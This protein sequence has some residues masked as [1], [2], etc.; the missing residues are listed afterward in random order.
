MDFCALSLAPACRMRKA[1]FITTFFP[2]SIDV[3]ED[4]EDVLD[5][6]FSQFCI[7]K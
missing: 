7:G 3:N 1:R 4:V 2:S 5:R 6:V